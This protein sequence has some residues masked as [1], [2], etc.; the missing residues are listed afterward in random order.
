MNPYKDEPMSTHGGQPSD[1]HL[2]LDPAIRPQD[3]E[4][5]PVATGGDAC[6]R[7]LTLLGNLQCHQ[8][9]LSAGASL[10]WERAAFGEVFTHPEPRLRIRRFL[11]RD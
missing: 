8:A 11:D 9:G 3:T 4:N 10:A 1:S 5:A 7:A 2:H 6:E